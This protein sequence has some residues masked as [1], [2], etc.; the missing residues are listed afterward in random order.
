M[1]VYVGSPFRI[2][3][4]DETETARI[5]L[6]DHIPHND[7]S[8]PH[9]QVESSYTQYKMSIYVPDVDCKKCSLQF[10][11]IMTDKSNICGIPECYYNPLDSACKGSTDPNAKT[12]YGAPNDTPCVQE[13]ECYSNCKYMYILYVYFLVYSSLFS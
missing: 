10:L 4:L 11:Y 12:C 3:I 7:A 2:A 13:D 1:H 8:S 6:L 5:V 9:S